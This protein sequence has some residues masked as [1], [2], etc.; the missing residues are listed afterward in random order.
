[1]M[2]MPQIQPSSIVAGLQ[3]SRNIIILPASCLRE[4]FFPQ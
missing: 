1:M 3:A 2:R 4:Q